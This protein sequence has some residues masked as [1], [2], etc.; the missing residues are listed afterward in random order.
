MLR[1]PR[2]RPPCTLVGRVL[3]LTLGLPWLDAYASRTQSDNG[4][5]LIGAHL[6][7]RLRHREDVSVVVAE[8]I[9]T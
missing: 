4:S 1:A 5:N 2:Y 9:L 7:P 3:T 8:A 6:P